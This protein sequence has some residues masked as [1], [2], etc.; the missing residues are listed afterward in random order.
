MSRT[1]TN[2]FILV[3]VSIRV[4]A[5]II[6]HLVRIFMGSTQMELLLV[7]YAIIWYCLP[8]LEMCGNLP[9]WSV[10][11]VSVASCT[12]IMMVCCLGTGS[13]F[14][15]CSNTVVDRTPCRWLL[16]WPCCVSSD[17][18]KCLCTF[19]TLMSSHIL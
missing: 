7:C 12:L 4:Y 9:V 17:S 13:I 14:S 11:M 15:A 6:S 2:T 18:R 5:S 19:L 8:R 10:Y 3:L 1:Y 16:M